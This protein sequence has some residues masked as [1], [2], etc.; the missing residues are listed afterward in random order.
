LC[1]FRTFYNEQ[2]PVST[3]TVYS[4][5]VNVLFKLWQKISVAFKS[6]KKCCNNEGITFVYLIG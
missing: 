5:G 4:C 6:S 3:S 2:E 1:V